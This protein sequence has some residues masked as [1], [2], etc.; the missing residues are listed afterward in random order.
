[1]YHMWPQRPS[2][3]KNMPRGFA[4]SIR[5]PRW[6]CPWLTLPTPPGMP[7]RRSGQGAAPAAASQHPCW[8]PWSLRKGKEESRVLPGAPDPW[9]KRHLPFCHARCM[10]PKLTPVTVRVRHL[11]VLWEHGQELFKGYYLRDSQGISS[12]GNWPLPARL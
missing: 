8:F 5:S 6:P 10:P 12:L 11:P 2:G 4:S 1:M 7:P 3:T 9:T